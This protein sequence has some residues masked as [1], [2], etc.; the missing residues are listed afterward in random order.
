MKRDQRVF[1]SVLENLIYCAEEERVCAWVGAWA[2]AGAWLRSPSPAEVANS[3]G[4]TQSRRRPR[5]SWTDA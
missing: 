5:E 3:E 1:K 4:S 2:G